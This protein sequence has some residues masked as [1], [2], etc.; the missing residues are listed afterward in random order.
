[1]DEVTQQNA[2][3][4]EEAAASAASLQDQA[5]RLRDTVSAFRVDEQHAGR[6]EPF[7]GADAVAKPVKTPTKPG[8]ATSAASAPKPAARAAEPKA[9]M[10]ARAEPATQ[11]P[12]AP[13]KA[14]TSPAVTTAAS[15]KASDDEWT[16]F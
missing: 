8:A 11:Q 3:L 16:T 7:A 2:A 14:A 15:A 4:V 5:A 13:A 10:P 12:K 9:A 6:V 1:M